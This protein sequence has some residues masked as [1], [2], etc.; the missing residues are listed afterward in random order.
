MILTRDVAVAATLETS[1][2]RRAIRRRRALEFAIS[3]QPEC[4]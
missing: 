3:S 2:A 1:R 4:R